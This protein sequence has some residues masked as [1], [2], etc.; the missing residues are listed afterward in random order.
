MRLY[1]LSRN[2]KA[3]QKASQWRHSLQRGSH[4]SLWHIHKSVVLTLA[5]VLSSYLK[6]DVFGQGSDVGAGAETPQRGIGS[7]GRNWGLADILQRQR[8]LTK[9]FQWFVAC[10]RVFTR[11][12]SGRYFKVIENLFIYKIHLLH[13]FGLTAGIQSVQNLIYP[14]EKKKKD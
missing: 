9:P 6:A 5:H 4:K 7:S 13:F 1:T 8:F 12:F 11:Q 14:S 10:A 3:Y 2:P